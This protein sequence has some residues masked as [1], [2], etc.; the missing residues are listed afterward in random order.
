[1]DIK[2]LEDKKILI[3][4]F[5]KEGRDTFSFLRKIF[6]DKV[7]GIADKEKIS[8]LRD[9]KVIIYSG[10]R[11]LDRINDYDLVFKSPGIPIHLPQ[12]AKSLKQGRITSQTKIFLENCPGK[13]V[14]ITGT[15]GKSTTSSLICKILKNGGIRA[16]LVG[17][18]GEPVLSHLLKAKK[19]DVFVCE[20]SSHQLH[21]LDKSP[22]VAVLLNVYPEHLD[23]YKNIKEYAGAK[24]NI[25]LHQGKDDYLIYNSKNR[26]V[27]E[28]AGKSK[29]RK[30]PIEGEY[31]DLD[32]KAAI[33]AAK[34]FKVPMKT[35]LKTIK[36]FKNLPYRMER[37]GTF[38]GITFYNDALATIPEATIG[39]I[40]SLG[41]DVETILLGGFERNIDFKILAEK[42]LKSK[43]K[44]VILFPT[45]GKKIWKQIVGLSRN[46]GV[47]KHFFTDSM[48]KAVKLAYENTGEK[49]ICLLSTASS[50]FSIF[51][52]YREKGDLFK[53][54]VIKY[55]KK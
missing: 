32:R 6:P 26:I 44:T 4:G 40:E 1:M 35:I 16:H 47:P 29:A 13:I 31:Y 22:Q 45:T 20:L 18:I 36:D 27:R 52:D 9:K 50:S 43:I 48:E 46:R 14:G 7:L 39:A 21:G 19:N 11:Y 38:K 54:Y 10:K 3:L 30:I 15:K 28:I 49:K 23:Y 12:V 55:G 5:G 41:D 37:V 34:I 17:N 33:E 25:T 24:A 51:K 2:K 42:I 53:K 8:G